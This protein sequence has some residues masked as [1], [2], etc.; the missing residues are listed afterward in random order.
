VPTIASRLGG[1]GRGGPISAFPRATFAE[2]AAVRAGGHDPL[3]LDVRRADER[4]AGALDGTVH[5]PVHE[6]PQ[7]LDELP[8]G[9]TVWVHCAAGYRASIAAGLLES[10]GRHVILIDDRFQAGS[11]HGHP[12]LTVAPRPL[13]Q[14]LGAS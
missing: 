10:A 14:P 5:V 4:R 9:R 8:A 2:V 1:L 7:R 11:D 13:P 6:L 3:V 12:T